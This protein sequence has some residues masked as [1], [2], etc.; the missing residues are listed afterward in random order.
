MYPNLYWAVDGRVEISQH[1]Y[2]DVTLGE[3]VRELSRAR[4][5]KRRERIVYRDNL[6]RSSRGQ[7]ARGRTV[8]VNDMLIEVNDFLADHANYHVVAESGD[9]A[10]EAKRE[11]LH[12]VAIGKMFGQQLR[13]NLVQI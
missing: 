1:R 8:D 2:S 7:L 9:I 5:P 11:R 3:F 10:I 6:K 4:L 12:I 13:G